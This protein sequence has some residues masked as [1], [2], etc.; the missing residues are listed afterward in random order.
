MFFSQSYQ[1]LVAR[2]EPV[3]MVCFPILIREKNYDETLF[4]QELERQ[5][6]VMV[7]THQ[8]VARCLLAYFLDKNQGTCDSFSMFCARCAEPSISR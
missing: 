5:E 3:I 1:D 7:I 8:A 4:F 2:L 6:N